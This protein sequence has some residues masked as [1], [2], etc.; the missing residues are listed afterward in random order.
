[1]VSKKKWDL[2][3][4][5]ASEDKEVV[6]RPLAEYLREKGYRVWYDEFSL[7]IGDSLKPY[8]VANALTSLPRVLTTTPRLSP[9]RMANSTN[10]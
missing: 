3:I 8:R 6:A 4:C 2:F 10:P 1:M 9:L 7:K 5:H